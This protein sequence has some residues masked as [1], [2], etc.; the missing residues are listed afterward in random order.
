MTRDRRAR[1]RGLIVRRVPVRLL[2]LSLSGCLIET[3]RAVPRGATGQLVIQL[4][5]VSYRDH[6]RIGRSARKPGST[7]S[8]RL[9]GEFSWGSRPEAGSVRRAASGLGSGP[10]FVRQER[11]HAH[12]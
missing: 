8:F 9:G 2:N 12:A 5:G 7:H 11:V 3:S 10:T 4:E 1:D 6:V